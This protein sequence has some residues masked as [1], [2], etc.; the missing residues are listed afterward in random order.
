MADEA[1]ETPIDPSPP[2]VESPRNW[3]VRRLVFYGF[4][5]V[6]VVVGAWNLYKPMPNGTQVRGEVVATPLNQLHFLT[7]V[8]G[9]DVFGAPI[10]DQQIFDAMLRVIGEARQYIV[11][12]AE[13]HHGVPSDTMY[14][15][16][17]QDAKAPA[18]RE[19]MT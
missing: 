19:E 6:W 11:L 13:E 3:H 9:A 15:A 18:R 8:T 12:D 16:A 17:N 7:D 4:L 1:D 14:V 5:L 10:V 2:P